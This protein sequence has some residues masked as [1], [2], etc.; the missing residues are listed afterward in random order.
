VV[1][2]K[3]EAKPGKLWSLHEMESTGGEPDVVGYDKKVGEYL[4]DCAAE[5]PQ[6][7]WSLC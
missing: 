3:L 4:Y 5:S 6:G 2:T 1:Q 7:R